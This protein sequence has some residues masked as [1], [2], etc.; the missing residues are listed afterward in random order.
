MNA[1][2]NAVTTKPTGNSETQAAK[3]ARSAIETVPLLA[4]PRIANV[5]VR[6]YRAREAI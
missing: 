5:N 2:K 4:E 6:S 1:A 3:D